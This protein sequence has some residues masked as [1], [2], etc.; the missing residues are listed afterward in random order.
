MMYNIYCILW[1]GGVIATAQL[2][3]LCQHDTSP[4]TKNITFGLWKLG[5]GSN[6]SSLCM[7]ETLHKAMN[8]AYQQLPTDSDT[9]GVG[10]CFVTV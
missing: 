4:G 10:W 1:G 7:E 2:G 3:Y 5:P 9:N 8:P 6:D